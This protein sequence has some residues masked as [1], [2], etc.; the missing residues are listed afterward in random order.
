MDQH[1][2]D[3]DLKALVE[4][5][6]SE[7]IEMTINGVHQV[8]NRDVLRSMNL[9]EAEI[10]AFAADPEGFT[11]ENKI[12]NM[13]RDRLLRML[14]ISK[15]NSMTYIDVDDEHVFVVGG[16]T[17]TT[18]VGGDGNNYTMVTL[19]TLAREPMTPTMQLIKLNTEKDYQPTVQ[20][21]HLVD[22]N[23]KLASMLMEAVLDNLC[24]DVRDQIY[25]ILTNH[26]C[27]D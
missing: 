17:M 16:V 2:T 26:H 9:T 7:K 15:P 3:E 11:T 22:G 21:I 12:F 6:D 25:D 5:T 1:I 27:G 18:G 8:V 4:S 24:D 13:L 23:Q 10:E 19:S 20:M 14:E